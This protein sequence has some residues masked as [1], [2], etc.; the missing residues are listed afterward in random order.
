M[1]REALFLAGE[2]FTKYRKLSGI[3]MGVLLDFFIGAH[4]AVAKLPLLTRDKSH[5]CSD[6]LTIT[7]ITPQS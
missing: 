4:G 1:P 7:L 5:Y 2:A 6:F 3:K